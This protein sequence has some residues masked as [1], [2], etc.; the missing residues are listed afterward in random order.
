MLIA[1]TFFYRPFVE[2]KLLNEKGLQVALDG[3]C[4]LYEC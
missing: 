2:D 4:Y 3:P 1:H